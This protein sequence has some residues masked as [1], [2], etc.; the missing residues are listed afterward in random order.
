MTPR[1]TAAAFS[2]H[3]PLAAEIGGR[4]GVEK[5]RPGLDQRLDLEPLEQRVPAVPIEVP[6]EHPALVIGA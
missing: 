4:W 3:P 1:S 5:G 2:P 6:R